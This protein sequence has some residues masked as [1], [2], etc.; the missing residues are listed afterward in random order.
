MITEQ[1]IFCG[2]IIKVPDEYAGKKVRCPKCKE[3]IGISKRQPEPAAPLDKAADASATVYPVFTT[4]KPS[5]ETVTSIVV[6]LGWA[7]LIVGA[8]GAAATLLLLPQMLPDIL[9]GPLK[10]ILALGFAL[11]SVIAGGVFCAI[12]ILVSQALRALTDIADKLDE[13]VKQND[14]IIE[15][16]R[17]KA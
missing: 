1:C 6:I 10:T 7:S 2:A 9:G 12:C 4:P 8:V 14:I 17:K 13:Q 5:A 11:A 3:A 15:L 16:L